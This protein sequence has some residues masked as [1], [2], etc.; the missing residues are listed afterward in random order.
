[1]F[2]W[3]RDGTKMHCHLADS[4][5]KRDLHMSNFYTTQQLRVRVVS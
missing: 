2:T 4:F 1:M 3:R 5:T